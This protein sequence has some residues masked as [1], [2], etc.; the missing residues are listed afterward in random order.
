MSKQERHNHTI[1]EKNLQEMNIYHPDGTI[2]STA[3]HQI[4]QRHANVL[5]EALLEKTL[6]ELQTNL[7]TSLSMRA[8]HVAAINLNLCFTTAIGYAPFDFLQIAEEKAAF[9]LYV[10]QIKSLL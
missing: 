2:N 7:K 6:L 8:F 5:R 3:I 4:A 10:N 9:H 1:L